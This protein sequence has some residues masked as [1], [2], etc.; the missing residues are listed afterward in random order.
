M[1][2]VGQRL[3]SRNRQAFPKRWQNKG[4]GGL[5]QPVH[6]RPLSQN[7]D[8]VCQSH[9]GCPI[10]EGLPA[11]AVSDEKQS[12]WFISLKKLPQNVQKELLILF[13]TKTGYTDDYL[14]VTQR[15][16][17]TDSGSEFR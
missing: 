12:N 4:V 7:A 15:E 8:L 2:A 3:N 6:I 17:L 5:K 1:Q 10:Q 16:F 14:F 13:R 11:G 9:G